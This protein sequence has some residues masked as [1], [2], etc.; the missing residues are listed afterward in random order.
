MK[1]PVSCIQINNHHSEAIAWTQADVVGMQ[2]KG[3][4]ERSSNENSQGKAEE[5]RIEAKASH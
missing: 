4:T 5:T 3:K 2:Q 1:E